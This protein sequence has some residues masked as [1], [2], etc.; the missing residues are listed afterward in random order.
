MNET[1]RIEDVRTIFPDKFGIKDK[2][3]TGM[4]QNPEFLT[5]TLKAY[6]LRLRLQEQELSI[7]ESIKTSENVSVFEHQIL[8]ALKIKN[9]LGGSG[10]LADEVGLGKTV[11]A[12]ILIKEFLV[13][14]LAKNDTHSCAP[15]PSAP[16]AGRDV[17]QV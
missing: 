3:R 16:V 8:A 2:L 5:L 1:P 15:V 11:E 7:A 10:I 12:G 9:E 6:D 4:V 13:T 14:G 17:N